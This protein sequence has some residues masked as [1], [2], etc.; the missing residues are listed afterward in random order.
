[1]LP[2]STTLEF[3]S[4]HRDADSLQLL[5]Q[6]GRYPDVDMNMVAQQIEGRRQAIH[7]WP[8]FLACDEYLFPP[9]LNREQSSSEAT[10]RYKGSLISDKTVADLTGGMGVDCYFVAR[11]ARE[12]HYIELNPDLV[13]LAQH[14]FSVLGKNNIQCHCGDSIQWLSNHPSVDVIIVDPARRNE[15]GK[16]VS[17]FEDCIPNI[18]EHRELL[19]SHSRTLIVKASPMIDINHGINQLGEVE[20]VHVVAVGGEC[21]EVLFVCRQGVGEPQIHCVNIMSEGSGQVW[22]FTRTQEQEANPRF[23]QSLGKYLYEPDASLMKGGAYRIICQWFPVE[24]LSRNSHLYTSDSLYDNFPGRI[25]QIERTLSLSPKTIKKELPE[26][27][28]HIVCRNY[29]LSAPELQK[30]L[31]LKEG[32][33]Q[34]IIATS[35]GE[36]PIGLVCR[37][38]RNTPVH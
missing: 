28:C 24:K 31:R 35:W 11:Q 18:L 1:M 32:G 38:V 3:L 37:Q 9:K 34:F 30:N 12:V 27:R 7:K 36:K 14:N 23:A 15:H 4:S 5:L 33:E 29:P 25:F 21:K 6:K 20:E 17:A 10:A 26:G 8:S 19:R 16:K 22:K 13:E 2:S